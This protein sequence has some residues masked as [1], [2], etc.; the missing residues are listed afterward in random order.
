MH[1]KPPQVTFRFLILV[2]TLF[3]LY[4]ILLYKQINTYMYNQKLHTNGIQKKVN[5]YPTNII[6]NLKA[7]NAH[8]QKY[9]KLHVLSNVS[10]KYYVFKFIRE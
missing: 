4:D 7:R 2:K 3:H 5:L 1:D 8:S 6:V 10:V 9:K